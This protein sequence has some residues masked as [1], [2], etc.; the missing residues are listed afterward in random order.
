VQPSQLL[1]SVDL[2]PSQ[3]A[4]TAALCSVYHPYKGR[5]IEFWSCNAP[6]VIFSSCLLKPQLHSSCRTALPLSRRVSDLFL[7]IHVNRHFMFNSE[8]S[9]KRRRVPL[10]QCIGPTFAFEPQSSAPSTLNEPN[11]PH[12]PPLTA[13][14]LDPALLPSDQL[15]RSSQLTIVSCT[16][17]SLPS[18]KLQFDPLSIPA[19]PLP[20]TCLPSQN[21]KVYCRR[22]L[23]LSGRRSAFS[24]FSRRVTYLVLCALAARSLVASDHL[25]FPCSPPL[26]PLRSKYA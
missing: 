17:H 2:K 21:A 6:L 25:D 1:S 18:C 12:T 19:S 11:S 24:C 14:V 20:C 26:C 15:A 3:Y 13:P 5:Q 8:S 4:C 16:G 7:V 10:H 23:K 9:S 22:S